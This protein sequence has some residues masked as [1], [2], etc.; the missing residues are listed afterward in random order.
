MTNISSH[1]ILSSQVDLVQIKDRRLLMECQ[2]QKIQYFSKIVYYLIT[3]VTAIGIILLTMRIFAYA[4]IWLGFPTEI[5]AIG[6]QNIVVPYLL[7]IYDINIFK[8]A[9]SDFGGPGIISDI[10]A[11][12]M[13]VTLVLA[14]RIFETL[15]ETGLPFSQ[16]VITGFKQFSIAFIITSISLNVFVTTLALIVF[17]FSYVLDYGRILQLESDTTL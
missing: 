15:K 12:T 3:V 8:F 1:D 17:A 10:R 5:I 4:W 14:R 6:E 16:E 11:A 9:I 13:L 7:H 2:K